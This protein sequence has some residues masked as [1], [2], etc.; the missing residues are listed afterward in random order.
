MYKVI[1]FS[2]PSG[3]GKS[4]IISHLLSKRSDIEFSISATTRKP[5]G[6]EKDGVDYYFIEADKFKEKI[7]KGEFLEWEE[8]YEGRYYGTLNTE[9]LRIWEKGNIVIFDV[10]VIGALNIKKKLGDKAISV[11][12]MPPSIDALAFRLQNRGTDSEETIATRLNKAKYEMGF[13]SQFDKTVI[14]DCLGD[15]CLEVEEIIKDFLN[16]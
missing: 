8:V 11:F 7:E 9:L 4:T 16:E 6:I 5:R 12:I 13:A 1:I 10:D 14:N 2:A 15:A 3:S